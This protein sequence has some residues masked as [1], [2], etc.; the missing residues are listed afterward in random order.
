MAGFV[1]GRDRVTLEALA[2]EETRR[3]HAAESTE[4][5]AVL[6][7]EDL[8]E[9]ERARTGGTAPRRKRSLLDRLLRRR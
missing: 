3:R 9:L 7:G 8:A 1:P 2:P 6:D 4:R 5:Q